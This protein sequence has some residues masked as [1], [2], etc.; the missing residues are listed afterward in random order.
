[1][2]KKEHINLLK[3]LTYNDFKASDANSFLGLFWSLLNPLLMLSVLYLLFNI[4]FGDRV[5][6]Y[7]IYLLIGITHFNH[8][9][10]ATSSSMRVLRSMKALTIN[11]IFPKELLVFS[12]IFSRSIPFLVSLL[13]CIAFALFTGLSINANYLYLPL[14]F[15]LQMLLVTWVSLLIS[16]IF[17]LVRDVE[18]IYQVFLRLLFFAC[19]VFYDIS[20][21]GHG[22]GKNIAY[23]NPLTHFMNM[24][25]SVIIGGGQIHP[26]EIFSLALI[27]IVLIFISLFIF[28]RLE[29][30]FVEYL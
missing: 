20:I 11:T 28:K 3:E 30:K 9:S 18:H 10:S 16:S 15:I 1:M 25:R 14:I 24:T 4:K 17:V 5:Q 26:T 7:G 29:H 23:L 19:P 27:N 12:S 22:L 8:Y 6:S 21:L 13:I 2:Y